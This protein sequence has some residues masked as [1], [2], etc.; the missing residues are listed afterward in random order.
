MVDGSPELLVDQAIL[1]EINSDSYMAYTVQVEEDRLNIAI[2]DMQRNL[3]DIDTTLSDANIRS[4]DHH[5][6]MLADAQAG[7]VL[8]DREGNWVRAQQYMLRPDNQTIQILNVSLR[9]GGDHKGLTSM[10]FT[11]TLNT[12]VSNSQDVSNLPWSEW[13]NTQGPDRPTEANSRFI[14]S[15]NNSL[16]S[17]SIQFTAPSGSYLLESRSFGSAN[18]AGQQT[19]INEKLDIFADGI[20]Q[21]YTYTSNW[22]SAPSNEYWA[23]INPSA[24][25]PHPRSFIYMQGTA[26]TDSSTIGTEISTVELFV[27]GDGHIARNSDLGISGNQ[28]VS[29]HSFSYEE[30]K[31]IWDVLR[32]NETDAGQIG[33]NNIEIVFNKGNTDRAIIDAVFIP[34]SRMVWQQ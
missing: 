17:M 33:D 31:D 11:T 6:A 15:S 32:A 8:Q 4:R 3:E 26:N 7:R 10:N 24:N 13:L 16:E 14:E 34:M 12:T 20:E 1:E 9:G 25:V 28:G 22:Q 21:Q 2:R 29:E 30:F 19:I 27:L 18:D 23:K 5:F